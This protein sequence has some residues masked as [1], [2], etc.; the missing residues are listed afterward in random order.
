LRLLRDAAESKPRF[1]FLTMG[2]L[3]EALGRVGK[4]AEGLAM[5][6]GEIVQ[7]EEGWLTSELLRLKGEFFY[8]RALMRIPKQR[9]NSSGRR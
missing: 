4:I 7:S 8:C 3:A 9:R 2:E 5:V 1:R 6:E